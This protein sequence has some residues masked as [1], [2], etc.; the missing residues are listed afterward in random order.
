MEYKA[1]IMQ[2][3]GDVATITLNRPERLNAI[4]R[5]M[6]VD[7]EHALEELKNDGVRALI[8]TGAGRGFCSGADVGGMAASQAGQQG[9]RPPGEALDRLRKPLGY[10]AVLLN[11]FPRPTIAAVNGVAVGAGLSF[12]LA[13]D[14]RIAAQSARF[15]AIFVRR[16]L[17]ADYG[18]TYFLPKVVGISK[19]LEMM[20]TGDILSAQEAERIGLVSKVV[21]DDQLLAS[22]KELATRLASG[23][24]IAHEIVKRITYKGLSSTLEEQIIREAQGSSV[25]QLTE[26]RLEGVRSFMEK[27]D[28]VF[29]GK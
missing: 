8:F 29:K 6:N 10:T 27:R 14:I 1:I 20:Y 12:A 18:C 23:P 2:R 26:D 17:V 15:S 21:P 28:P 11:S 22:A 9:E 13:C 5:E 24:S 4:T 25:V 16:A 3:E 7:L 19:A